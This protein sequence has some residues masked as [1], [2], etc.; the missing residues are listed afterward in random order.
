ME[1]PIATST[2]D[3]VSTA[4]NGSVRRPSN[5]S[6]RD[7]TKISQRQTTSSTSQALFTLS[8]LGTGIISL[9]AL[10]PRLAFSGDPRD[11]PLI[12]VLFIIQQVFSVL[13]AFLYVIGAR[14]LRQLRYLQKRTNWLFNEDFAEDSERSERR[15]WS[16]LSLDHPVNIV[17]QVV[18]ASVI[19]LVV[20]V[21]T[22]AFG[23]RHIHHVFKWIGCLRL[24][25]L[26]CFRSAFTLLATNLSIPHS[27]TP[28]LRSILVLCFTTHY[29]ACCYWLLARIKDFSEDT[30]VGAH[31]SFLID[32]SANL[33]YIHSLYFA[34]ITTS[35]VGYG[36][37]SPVSKTETIVTICYV[38][39]NVFLVANIIGVISSLAAIQDTDLSEQRKR[40]S[41]FEKML[42]RERLSPEVVV[43]TREY[44]RQGLSSEDADIDLLPKAVA[45]RIRTERF[46][47]VLKQL[48]LLR[49]TTDR[50]MR[51][52]IAVVKEDS[53]VKGINIV[54]EGDIG[55]RIVVIIEGHATA[56]ITEERA[57]MRQVAILHRY[58]SFCAESF[59]CGLPQPFTVCARSNM[60]VI[61]IS[62]EDRRELEKSFPHDWS[63]MR[64]NLLD[65]A[66]TVHQ[67]ADILLTDIR[68]G[69]TSDQK[70]KIESQRM[71]L[72][73]S[74]VM[75]P[76]VAERLFE[77]TA[78]IIEQI[79]RDAQRATHELS[80]LHCH[81]AACGDVKELKRLVDLV[82]L[83]QV[84]NDY[85]HRSALHLAAACGR[86]DCVALLL[87]AGGDANQVDR[88]DRTPLMEAVLNAHDD[89]IELLR[90]HGAELKLNAHRQGMYLCQAASV[91]DLPLI[92]RYLAAG[93]DPNTSDYDRRTALH[94][95]AAEGSTLMC[96]RLLEA[97]ANPRAKD[98]W[99]NTPAHEAK[100]FGHSG[101]LCDLLFEAEANTDLDD[102]TQPAEASTADE[103][104]KE[105]SA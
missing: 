21:T 56:E 8:L 11:E 61:S 78:S 88:F 73:A 14:Y 46:E 31:R 98:R 103:E 9:F 101:T 72:E 33:Q 59:V 90:A 70:L 83:S 16:I 5:P 32:A 50:F 64:S 27:V 100:R 92:S 58:S 18:C 75:E 95:A 77:A 24:L 66:H 65:Q 30:W 26:L 71:S 102:T 23:T 80:A 55:G 74:S 86:L 36:D 82:P 69:T 20:D 63:K 38:L 53:Y 48:P 87:S 37:I 67:Y 42:R 49:G 52:C 105:E 29:F 84:H 76:A 10:A 79:E 97:G 3:S 22:F 81:V 43:A 104:T 35:T 94:I 62:N 28:L 44:L 51:E 34:V 6:I 91:G 99:D 25:H 57:V 17:L 89:I 1:R 60:R 96:R 7:V 68:Q 4:P 85:D 45:T 15:R 41:R 40:I 47:K 2:F 12:S 13:F 19:P 54:E 93:V 39:M